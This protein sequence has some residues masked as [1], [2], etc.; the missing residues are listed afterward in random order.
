MDNSL[1]QWI[2]LVPV[3]AGALVFLCPRRLNKLAHLLTLGTSIWLVIAAYQLKSHIGSNWQ[4]NWLELGAMVIGVNL[5][6]SQFG[7]VIVGFTALFGALLSLY[8]IGF[9]TEKVGKHNS[10]I[11]WT[12]AGAIGAA[13]ANN[14]IFLLICWEIVTLMLF[15]LIGLGGEQ[16]K[17][18]AFKSFTILGLG[19]AALLL[20]IMIMLFGLSNPTLAMDQLH[21]TVDSPLAIICFLLFA[22]AAC[23]KAGAMPLHTWIPAAAEGAPTDVMAFLPAALDKLLGIYLLARVSLE[24]FVLTAGLKMLLLIV[25]A[26]TIVG[27]VMLAMVQHDLKKLLSFHAISQVGYMVLGIGTG[28]LLGIAGALF[29]MINNAIYKSC[30]FLAAGAVEKKAGTTDLDKLGGLAR[31]M[32]WTFVACAISALAISGI[33]PLNGFTSKWLI[34][35]AALDVPSR[36]AP[37]LVM[38]AIFGSALTL[39]SF[40][41]VVHSVFLGSPTLEMSRKKPTEVSSW[42][43]VPM[44][45][46]AVL[47]VVFG[48][49][50]YMPMESY[51]IPSFN[52]LLSRS[53]TESE[54]AELTTLWRPTL[55]TG[56]LVLGLIIGIV[57]FY[58]GR[59]FKIRRTRTYIGGERLPQE[60]FHYSGTGFYATVRNLPGLK[61]FY[62]AASQQL[63][64]LYKILGFF[65]SGLLER[66][67]L[68]HS[69]ALTLYVSWVVLGLLII[70]MFLIGPR[71]G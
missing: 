23:A 45:V 21:V 59:G 65:G 36:L 69:G 52:T 39:A 40:V 15:L 3:I 51:I 58:L 48:V 60:S 55:A 68:L 57:I 14:L 25:G 43:K 9:T 17:Q 12:L 64:D 24:F 37:V 56:L 10:Y 20:G 33:P 66:F 35:Q 62:Q 8:C 27:A 7:L 26:V 11:L 32:P 61:G 41:K 71:V 28:S 46:L 5:K 31:A 1:L 16:A 22:V 44:M 34:Y 53:L 30:L 70:L 54:I 38:A 67:R 4:W 19:D 50:A 18:G 49:F 6:V 2:M 47:C 13:L 63:F 42:M 29:H